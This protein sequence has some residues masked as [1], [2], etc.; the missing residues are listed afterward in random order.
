MDENFFDFAKS[1]KIAYSQS[2]TYIQNRDTNRMEISIILNSYSN[3]EMKSSQKI[4]GG[5]KK[6]RKQR[7]YNRKSVNATVVRSPCGYVKYSP[8]L[9]TLDRLWFDWK[10]FY[11]VCTTA[12]KI[13]K[14]RGRAHSHSN[15][16]LICLLQTKAPFCVIW[17]MFF[18]HRPLN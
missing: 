1:N 17:W 5:E 6:R 18:F 4:N 12:N 15:K 8:V 3:I 2:I 14:A 13:S 11:P 16:Q 10:S 9:I 7:L